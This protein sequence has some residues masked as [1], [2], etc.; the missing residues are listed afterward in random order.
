MISARHFANYFLLLRFFFISPGNKEKQRVM[1]TYIRYSWELHHKTLKIILPLKQFN[2][3]RSTWCFSIFP[4]TKR[5]SAKGRSSLDKS[6]HN[7]K[8]SL[9]PLWVSFTHGG[10]LGAFT[11]C[12][13]WLTGSTSPTKRRTVSGQTD[14]LLERRPV[15]SCAAFFVRVCKPTE[16]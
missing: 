7:L 8:Q 3:L 2:W 15:W 13:K 5:V 6:T 12:Q 4:K 14:P 16:P 1:L 10:K 9:K 11:I